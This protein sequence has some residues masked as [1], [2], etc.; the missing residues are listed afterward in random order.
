MKLYEGI[1]VDNNDNIIFNWNYDDHN[2]DCLY[3][4]GLEAKDFDEQGI[5]YVYAYNY[6]SNAY[7]KDKKI[8][9][10]YLKSKQ[11][12]QDDNV[13]DLVDN[14][15][16]KLDAIKPLKSLSTIITIKSS[17]PYSL[18]NLIHLYLTEYGANQYIDFELVKETYDNIEVNYELISNEL[19][20]LHWDSVRIED[21]IN[22][23]KDRFESW[24]QKGFLF[25]MKKILPSK[26]RPAF[27]NFLKFKTDEQKQIYKQLQ[28]TEV[29]IYDDFLTSG[30]TVKEI[31]RYLKAI[32]PNNKLTVFVLI[33]QRD[34]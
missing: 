30:S 14:G 18:T 32:N 16:L 9:R 2:K 33:N 1:R 26:I 5:R 4:D 8:I 20:K 13:R 23:F 10:Q 22:D 27:T 25:E 15:I 31:I 11:G 6:T 3:L 29:L 34:I 28:N 7:E 21:F 17:K 24:K 19:R 12:F